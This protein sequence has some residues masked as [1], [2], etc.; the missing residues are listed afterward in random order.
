MRPP[1]HFLAFEKSFKVVVVVR[2]KNWVVKSEMSNMSID[3][4]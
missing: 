4:V 1:P 3:F 2:R